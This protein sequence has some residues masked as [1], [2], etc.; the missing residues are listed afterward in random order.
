MKGDSFQVTSI[1]KESQNEVVEAWTGKLIGNDFA[2]TA[3]GKRNNGDV[4]RFELK[5]PVSRRDETLTLSGGMFVEAKKIRECQLSVALQEAHLVVPEFSTT[6]LWQGTED[7]TQ[8]QQMLATLV[9][10]DTLSKQPV[11][12]DQ[13]KKS[14]I[15]DAKLTLAVMNSLDALGLNIFIDKN[16][17]LFKRDLSG[18]A[19][20][21]DGKM[22]I[23]ILLLNSLTRTQGRSLLQSAALTL[24]LATD[25][26]KASIDTRDYQQTLGDLIGK[27]LADK[28]IK[29]AA[30]SQGGTPQFSIEFVPIDWSDRGE[31][32]E[33]IGRRFPIVIAFDAQIDPAEGT[34]IVL[35]RQ[36]ATTAAN[37]RQ[38]QAYE[39]RVAQFKTRLSQTNF[40]VLGTPSVQE[41]VTLRTAQITALNTERD[42]LKNE[43]LDRIARID[44]AVA[45]K[46]EL[47]GALR[48]YSKGEALTANPKEV[49]CTVTT[50]DAL[51]LKGLAASAEFVSWSK[52]P[53]GSRFTQV[54]EN[55]KA[56]YEAINAKK[57]G[58]IID[59]ASN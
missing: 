52:I 21:G 34:D 41:L 25:P 42:R 27:L 10:K 56:M 36:N 17:P 47:V 16:D 9:A 7:K 18:D 54:F 49:F 19:T 50:D 35:Y 26:S 24:A 58:V 22:P 44:D 28:G 55:A 12:E 3:N 15:E 46:A 6:L 30:S 43:M 1:N 29:P 33:L 57:C 53:T 23:R 31:A 14:A 59:Q 39:Q 8:L 11:G 32:L 20:L 51:M 38:R 45:N 40:E 4:W 37:A 5:G 13:I 48:I 2:V